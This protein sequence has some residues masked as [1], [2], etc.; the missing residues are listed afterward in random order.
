M[1]SSL[2]FRNIM[3]KP[4]LVALFL[5]TLPLSAEE[6]DDDTYFKSSIGA[7][8]VAGAIF[9]GVVSFVFMRH[10]RDSPCEEHNVAMGIL[11]GII[12]GLMSLGWG[13]WSEEHVQDDIYGIMTTAGLSSA[14]NPLIFYP[15]LSSLFSFVKG[16][17]KMPCRRSARIGL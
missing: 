14:T 4:L 9:G 6:L 8:A 2:P 1:V 11:S 17:L 5:C 16:H 10:C 7:S 3:A 12:S 15:P 13:M